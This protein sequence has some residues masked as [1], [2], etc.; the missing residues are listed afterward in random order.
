MRKKVLAYR[1]KKEGKTDYK[2]RLTLLLGNKPRLVIRKSNK[3]LGVQLIDYSPDGDVVLAAAHTSQLKKYGWATSMSNIPAAYLTGMLLGK[4]ALQKKI[5]EAILDIGL[6]PSTKGSR[7]YAAVKG[8]VDAGL[9]VPHGEEIL[10]AT[11]KLS[12]GHIAAYAQ[13]M[14]KEGPEK[15]QKHNSKYL[16]KKVE[17]ESF[18]KY[19]DKIKE[20]IQNEGRRE[21]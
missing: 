16:A 15:F 18:Q 1:R 13:K 14:K 8:A 7:L 17:P 12:G 21:S 10:P 2:K 3:G 19:F 11:E 9:K 6:Y 5:D 20:Q 4:R